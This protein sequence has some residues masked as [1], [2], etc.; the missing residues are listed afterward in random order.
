VLEAVFGDQAVRRLA[1]TA[2]EELDT[3]IE[4][5]MATELLRYHAL[6]DATPVDP[7]SAARLRAAADAVQ[8]ARADGLPSAT[9]DA[10]EAE[11][12]LAAAEE[13]RA[14]APPTVTQVP[15]AVDQ[16]DD[17]LDAELVEPAPVRREDLR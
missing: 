8:R 6:L 13:R 10:E 3:R 5:L 1:E 9:A 15:Y 7:A 17:V 4:A 12:A 11:P 2:K 14:I 16:D